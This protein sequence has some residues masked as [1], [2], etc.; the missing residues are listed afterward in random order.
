[1]LTD[2]YTVKFFAEAGIQI[3]SVGSRLYGDSPIG[4]RCVEVI[5]KCPSPNTLNAMTSLYDGVSYFS[6]LDGPTNTIQ[7]LNFFD[8]LCQNTSPTTERPLLECGDIVIM[9]TG[10]KLPGGM[11][12]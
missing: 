10:P 5:R 4:E 7:F 2:P 8:E 9:D 3:F 1:M 12:G 6:I 11:G